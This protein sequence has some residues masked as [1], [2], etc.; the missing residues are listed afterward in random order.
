MPEAAARPCAGHASWSAAAP[1]A[2]GAGRREVLRALRAELLRT[3][4]ERGG[5]LHLRARARIARCDDLDRLARWLVRAG[6]GDALATALAE[7][8]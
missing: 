8:D 6:R 3:I 4:A 5:S 2:L 1:G 7:A